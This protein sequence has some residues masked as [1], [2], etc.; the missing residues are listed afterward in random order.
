MLVRMFEYGAQIALDG[1][2]VKGEVLEV[3]F[4]HAAVLFLRHNSTTPDI[5]RIKIVTPEG[6]VGY[7]IPVVKLQEYTLE[8]V[9]GKE[10]LFLLP[11][12]LL[13][14]KAGL[15][16]ICRKVKSWKCCWGSTYI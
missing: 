3:E 16:N 11:F 5:M 10:L 6:G 7:R 15:G 13:S 2:R 12:Y 9:F 8:E 1:I 4:P 14:M